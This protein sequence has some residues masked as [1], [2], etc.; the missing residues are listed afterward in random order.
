LIKCPLTSN[1]LHDQ[2]KNYSPWK[3]AHRPER[4]NTCQQSCE[5]ML[6]KGQ[7]SEQLIT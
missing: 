1:P 7:C 4:Q 6:T 2:L 5:P 3:C